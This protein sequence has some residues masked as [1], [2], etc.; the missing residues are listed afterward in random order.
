MTRDSEGAQRHAEIDSTGCAIP[1]TQYLRPRGRRRAVITH[2]P[3]ALFEKVNAILDAGYVFESE[4]LRDGNTVVL[5]ITDRETDDYAIRLCHNSKE[6]VENVRLLVE[7]FDLDTANRR[8]DT[9]RADIRGIVD[10]I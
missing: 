3:A 1:F 6:V 4:L 8:R 2:V 7:E 5:T 9:I 10:D